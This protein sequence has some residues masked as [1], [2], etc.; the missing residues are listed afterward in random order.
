MMQA[1]MINL[2]ITTK[3]STVGDQSSQ[4]FLKVFPDFETTL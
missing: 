2:D 3:P 1:I 4:S